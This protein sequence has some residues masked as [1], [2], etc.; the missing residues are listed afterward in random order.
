MPFYYT[1]EEF[2]DDHR[3]LA[4]TVRAFMDSEVYP[5]SNRIDSGDFEL[6]KKLLGRAGELGLLG[7]DFGMVESA[8]VAEGV[9]HQGSFSV[10]V[11]GHTGIGTLPIVMYGND[12]Q[13]ARL[14]PE[15]AAGNLIGAF[16]LTERN[17]GSDALSVETTAVPSDDGSSYL[18]GGEKIYC[19]SGNI[20]DLFTVFAKVE[21]RGLAAFLVERNT[22]GFAI[23]EGENMMGLGGLAAVPLSFSDVRV[24]SGN[25]LGELGRGHKIALNVLN[26]G[27]LKLGASCIGNSKRLI[28]EMVRCAKSRKRFGRPIADFELV[29]QKIARSACR[30]YM[31]ESLIYRLAGA[32]DAA[33]GDV[34]NTSERFAA[35]CAIAKVY[36]SETIAFVSDEAVQISGGEG[37]MRGNMV[38]RAYRD[39]RIDRIF[40]GTNEINRLLIASAYVK[41]VIASEAKQ[42]RPAGENGIASPLTGLAMTTHDVVT[43]AVKT[44]GDS[45]KS[46][47]SVLS[48]ISDLII[49]SYALESG[50]AR[51]MAT[52]NEHY[53][54]I[55]EVTIAERMPALLNLARQTMINVTGNC[56]NIEICE[57]LAVNTD[58][59]YGEIV[60][61]IL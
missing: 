30:V 55:C 32:M 37:Y 44:L 23:G 29:R 7:V 26:I 21:G 16:A 49:E 48:N 1:P 12:E 59:L 2:S 41:N 46:R 40:E 4:A 31:L 35:E 43:T 17:T 11:I 38:E 14:L 13:K 24:S 51:A 54:R 50:L 36:G 47:Q 57:P 58:A 27:R 18:L 61:E 33:G 52:Q 25:L 22:P 60:E 10:A 3:S 42:S 9:A 53:R 45:L 56:D 8:I 34:R 39:F 6:V 15:L 19:A 20:A 5:Q 28:G